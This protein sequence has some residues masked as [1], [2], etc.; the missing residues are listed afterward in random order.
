M[1]MNTNFTIWLKSHS[2]PFLLS[3]PL[4]I[5]ALIAQLI[6]DML[7]IRI[8]TVLFINLILVLGLQ[9]FMGNSG[10]LSFAHLGFMGIGAYASVLF[11][12]T[13]EAKAATLP[14]LYPFLRP[15][16]LPFIPSI[17][18]GALVAAL[19]AAIVGYALMR[20]SD[21]AAVITLFALL[22]IIHTVLVHWSIIT[23][24]PRT[25]FGVD[26]YTHL[27]NSAAF[28]ILVIFIAYF[29]KEFPIGLKL[30]ASRDDRYA[31]ASIGI[32]IVQVRWYG[33]ILSAFLAGFAGGLWAHFITSFSPYA[34]YLSE[35]FGILAMLV[36]GGT[37]G[38]SGAVLGTVVITLAREGLRGI[39]NYININHLLPT[40]LV[41][42]TE[43]LLSIVLIAILIFRPSGI[44]G[45]R[46][47]ALAEKQQAFDEPPSKPHLPS[48]N[49]PQGD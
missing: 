37:G 5:L 25:L 31:A 46:E 19:V 38:V 35:T 6:G 44:L 29:F 30:R 24:G 1:K 32:N 20:L 13:P 12:M 14:D 34:F 22:V 43:V 28:G 2:T 39:E 33:F 41:G 4:I 15:I 42:F 7:I 23:N 17:L 40:T 16:H 47:I 18:I 49:L 21:A 9:V 27:W 48:Q 11:S 26:N 10:I 45:S 36:I 8:A 3:I